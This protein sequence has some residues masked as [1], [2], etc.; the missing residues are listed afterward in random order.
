MV[1]IGHAAVIP[2]LRT[3]KNPIE[4][5]RWEAAKTLDAIGDPAAADALVEALDD[6]SDDVR[7]VA[8]QALIA[9][10]WD[11]AKQVLISLLRNADSNGVCAAHITCCRTSPSAN[12]VSFSSRS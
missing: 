8:A 1:D 12:Q 11:A 2:L 5:V 6:A 9:L 10:G 7:W 4:H 3:L